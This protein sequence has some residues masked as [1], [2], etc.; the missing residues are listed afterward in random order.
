MNHELFSQFSNS[1]LNVWLSTFYLHVLYYFQR[2]KT[3][4]KKCS[5]CQTHEPSTF[6]PTGGTSCNS[7]EQTSQVIVSEGA[8]VTMNCTYMPTGY[9]TLFWYV[10]NPN[11]P[12]QFL[13]REMVDNSKNFGARN[14][15]DRSSSIVKF[16]VQVSNS[17]MYYC[18]LRDTFR[19]HGENYENLKCPGEVC[20]ETGNLKL[21]SPMIS[22]TQP[23]G[24]LLEDREK[25]N[26]L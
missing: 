10:Q 4:S 15:K 2:M 20:S 19:V 11:K 22:H 3:S 26:Q 7:V 18:L 17:A 16:S 1:D 21:R 23:I 5:S 9:S 8:S 24:A 25:Q 6:F 12:L 13:Q 14:L